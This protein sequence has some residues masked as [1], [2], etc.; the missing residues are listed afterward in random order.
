MNDGLLEV[1]IIKKPHVIY[2]PILLFLIITNQIYKS[3]LIQNISCHKLNINTDS[4]LFH[5]DGDTKKTSENYVIK[6][7]KE[8]LNVIVP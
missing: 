1:V 6:I 3:K 7:K 2:F 5:I 8:F 4:M